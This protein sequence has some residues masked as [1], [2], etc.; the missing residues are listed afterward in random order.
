MTDHVTKKNPV[1]HKKSL[2]EYFIEVLGWL[3]IVASP[4]VISSIIG[5]VI[6]FSTPTTTR[7]IIAIIII[8]IG[9]AIGIIWANRVWKKNG[10]I[11]FMSR[12]MA[13]PELDKDNEDPK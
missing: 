2:F 1:H 11:R 9:L 13:S 8:I 12:I 6:Y 4:F 10:T 5:A 7:L 3:Q